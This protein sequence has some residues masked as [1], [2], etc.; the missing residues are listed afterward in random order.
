MSSLYLH[1]GCVCLSW[2]LTISETAWKRATV[3]LMETA[4]KKCLGYSSAPWETSCARSCSILVSTVCTCATPSSP[5]TGSFKKIL[6]HTLHSILKPAGR[7]LVIR[8]CL[9]D[10]KLGMAGQKL[11]ASALLCYVH[12]EQ[13]DP[14]ASFS[15]TVANVGTCQAVLCRDGRP[16]PLSKVYSLENSTE[17]MERI[18]LTKAIIT[19]VMQLLHML[20]SRRCPIAVE[21][22]ELHVNTSLTLGLLCT[23]IRHSNSVCFVG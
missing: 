2:L 6:F 12:R 19:E 8:V 23:L 3:Y 1:P 15:L 9:L 10:R 11:G 5:R 21:Y 7:E 13:S 4:T 14:G 16:V 20:N 22:A 18:K 17:E